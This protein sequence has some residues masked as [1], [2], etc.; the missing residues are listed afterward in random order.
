M[1]QLISHWGAN[2]LVYFLSNAFF[3]TTKKTNLHLL[4]HLIN[5][6]KLL[7]WLNNKQFNLFLPLETQSKGFISSH[8]SINPINDQL[9]RKR[10]EKSCA[11]Q[12]WHSNE[13]QHHMSVIICTKKAF[14]NQITYFCGYRFVIV[15]LLIC[16]Q[17]FDSL[18]DGRIFVWEQYRLL[19]NLNTWPLNNKVQSTLLIKKRNLFY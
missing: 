4:L 19:S 15:K 17:P 14:I 6:I 2:S 9:R 8:N 18:L 11:V 3:T 13:N 7:L 12:Q 10:W 1:Q 16:W 5:T